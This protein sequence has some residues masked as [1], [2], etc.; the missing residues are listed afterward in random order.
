MSGCKGQ[1][2]WSVTNI[3]YLSLAVYHSQSAVQSANGLPLTRSGRIIKCE[4]RRPNQSLAQS[5]ISTILTLLSLLIVLKAFTRETSTGHDLRETMLTF[6]RL[7][8]ILIQVVLPYFF[9]SNLRLSER[10]KMNES[11]AQ[12]GITASTSCSDN[13]IQKIYFNMHYRYTNG[14]NHG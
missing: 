10:F 4:R 14:E 7:M 2:C 5:K 1:D 6:R 12:I 13:L 3:A 8:V 9:W 11:S